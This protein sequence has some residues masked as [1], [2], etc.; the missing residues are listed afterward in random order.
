MNSETTSLISIL[1]SMALAGG[2]TLA[3]YMKG[4]L[5]EKK[6]PLS[7]PKKIGGL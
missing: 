5:I 4:N 6:V 2:T 3:F 1:V 7:K